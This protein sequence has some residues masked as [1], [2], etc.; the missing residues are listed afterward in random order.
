MSAQKHEGSVTE[1]GR[2]VR[3]SLPEVQAGD[4]SRTWAPHG[5][6]G[7]EAETLGVWERRE[8]PRSRYTWSHIA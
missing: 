1:T 4:V 6:S 5:A 8:P 3:L 2:G 7:R